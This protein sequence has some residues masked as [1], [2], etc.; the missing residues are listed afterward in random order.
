MRLSFFVVLVQVSAGL[1]LLGLALFVFVSSRERRRVQPFLLMAGVC[2]AWVL[3]DGLRVAAAYSGGPAG[4]IS[5]IGG[6]FVVFTG[7][8]VLNFAFRHPYNTPSPAAHRILLV[9]GVVAL[10]VSLFAW[11]DRW[12]FNRRIENGI[13][14]ADIGAPYLVT[15]GFTLVMLFWA[16]GLLVAKYR[17]TT[18]PAQRAYILYAV[19]GISVFAFLA[20]FF[21]LL[22]PL[23][24]LRYLF[25]VGPT[26]AILF[27]FV[28]LH[29]IVSRRLFDL[30]E[31]LE[32]FLIGALF[33]TVGALGFYGLQSLFVGLE[34]PLRPGESAILFAASLGGSYVLLHRVRPF[35]RDRLVPPGYRIDEFINQIT[36][37]CTASARGGPEDMCQ[38]LSDLFCK[39]VR[40]ERVLVAVPASGGSYRLL[41]SGD[42]KPFSEAGKRYMRILRRVAP[43]IVRQAPATFWVEDISPTTAIIQSALYPR[44]H[45]YVRA[46]RSSLLDHRIDLF[47]PFLYRNEIVAY[48]FLGRKLDN[49]PFYNKEVNRFAALTGVMAVGIKNNQ[50]FGEVVRLQNRLARENTALVRSSS[51]L[52]QKIVSLAQGRRL[53]YRSERMDSVV[54]HLEKAAANQETVLITGESGTGKEL[55]AAIIHQKSARSGRPF[56]AVNCGAFSESLLEAELFGYERGAFTGAVRAYAG[57]FEQAQGG[58]LFLD[59]VGELPLNVQVRLLRVLQERTVT[60]L[61][62]RPMSLDVR[63]VCATNRDLAGAVERGQFRSDL[64][65]RIN[66]IR[67]E[68]P[69]LRERQSDIAPLVDYY[70]ETFAD[71]LGRPGLQIAVDALKELERHQWPGNVRELENTMI[72]AIVNSQGGFL[73][74]ETVRD[75]LDGSAAPEA[76]AVNAPLPDEGRMLEEAELSAIRRALSLSGGNKSQAAR[77][78]GLSRSTFYEKLRRWKIG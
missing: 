8:A 17:A 20:Y 61:G 11:S 44:V 50:A 27:F 41:G 77:M 73:S 58:V 29:A 30:R 25:F 32:R 6:M 34:T 76:L 47:I 7:W 46:F 14:V 69:P 21:S 63:I 10:V 78:L 24:G 49:R 71:R 38:R 19:L 51:V 15:S 37:V 56:V 16:I 40:L 74:A 65:Y 28:F 2:A 4:L 13:P 60:R 12:V 3:T 57:V 54:A 5:P 23:L 75:N 43:A 48:L 64:Y 67:I 68:M 66:V 33:L 53:V 9:A 55:G 52:T 18:L 62:G 59:E 42:F 35:V 70:L 31:S 1:I 36:E 45:D 39:S 22:L 72:R 26:S